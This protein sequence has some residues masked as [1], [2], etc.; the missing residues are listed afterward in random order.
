M[1][2]KKYQ[3]WSKKELIR[4]VERLKER[5]KYGLVWEDKPEDVVER[6]KHELPVLDE[7][8]DREVK[9]DP[10]KPVNLFI[11]G[12]NYHALSVLNYTHK[13]KVDVIYI[14]P[15]YNTGK[16]KEWKF[17]DK[18]VDQNDSYKHSKWL[19]FISIRLLLAK[20][21]L[22]PR[23]V[24]FIS[25]DDNEYA[26][27]KLLCDEIF[28]ER[29][30]VGTLVW[31]KKKK[32]SHLDSY[33][34]NIKEYVL[35]YR[36]SNEFFGLVG[37]KTDK[38]ETYP[39]L[40]PGNGYTLRVIPKGTRSNYQKKNHV[41]KEGETISAGN[42]QLIL[43]SDLV[44]KDGALENDVK[45]EAEWRY[46]QD[47]IDEF[48]KRGTLYL[49]RDLYV[50]HVVTKMRMKKLKD[51]LPRVESSHLIDLKEELLEECSKDDPSFEK[52]ESLKSEI[53]ESKTGEHKVSLDNLSKNGWG[54]NEDADEE[55][56]EFFGK[57]VFDYPK[58]TKLIKKLI[59]ST[60]IK[61][62]LVLD[63]FAGT[64][65]T[66]HAVLELNQHGF[67]SKFILSTNNE[68]NNGDGIKIATDICYPRIEKI[69][70]GYKNRAGK[71]IE[72]LG[73]N[74]KYYYTSFVPAEPTD[75]NKTELTEKAT[76]MLCI[77]E[78]TFNL[79]KKAK[80]FK[81]FRNKNMD[82][83]TG[84]IYDQLAIPVFKKEIENRD[85]K[86]SVYIFS[87]GDDTFEE[88]FEDMKEK[89]TLS[90]IPGAILR[91]YRRIFR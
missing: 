78:D 62:A 67:N 65:T 77:K 41:L 26:T 87:L 74:L 4:E 17:N 29:K 89:V 83:F 61:D 86:Y 43:H 36:K 71:K 60:R 12:D 35:V 58:P 20:H 88:E 84:I 10:D 73:G 25:I 6:C 70:E 51:L 46:S 28:D 1:S 49:T 53:K 27:L 8:Q 52:I 18:W 57:K 45:I 13:G 5:K 2:D 50:R 19:S 47:K 24:I 31:E 22:S 44:I 80:S 82:K 66:A 16:S 55:Q 3:D 34:T 38:R 21:I 14:D 15:P 68:D 9:T 42:M 75:K 90:P 11:E 30:Y 39:C 72:G 91:V 32:G 69:I 76:E 63:F 79:V 33:I 54:S 85:G 81:I 23:G 59:A 7:V 37:I 48:A 56:R 40:N 64:G